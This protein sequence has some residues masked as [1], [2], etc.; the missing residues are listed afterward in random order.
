MHSNHAL[1]KQMTGSNP[2]MAGSHLHLLGVNA[3][4]LGPDE[5]VGVTVGPM[6]PL[7]AS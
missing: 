1:H 6:P 7:F 2:S 5:V 4:A 3:F